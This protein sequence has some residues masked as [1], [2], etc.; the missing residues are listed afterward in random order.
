M[1]KWI[2]EVRRA[3]GEPFRPMPHRTFDTR[4]EAKQ[5]MEAIKAKFPRFGTW[6]VRQAESPSLR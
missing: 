5:R 6:R 2:I 4:K 3:S 1:S